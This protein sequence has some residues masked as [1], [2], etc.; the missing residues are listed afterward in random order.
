MPQIKA[1][2]IR[3][4]NVLKI[5][6]DLLVVEHMEH[7]TPGNWRAIIHTKL[8][9]LTTKNRTPKRFSSNDNVERVDLDT[10]WMQ[11]IYDQ[12]DEAVFMDINTF[13]QYHIR[14]EDIEDD[15]K[16][17]SHNDTVQVT[18]NGHD[19]IA[20]ELPTSVVLEVVEADPAVKGNTA[21]NVTK[22]ITLN[23]GLVVKA[24]PHISVGEKVKID[25]R[26][27]EFLERSRE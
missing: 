23:T 7:I 10:K 1:T 24:P 3:R 12:D 25:T 14:K 21:T 15:L 11:Y 19:P 16:Y 5:D 13:E 20:I 6:N 8:R 4:G 17:I 22:N 9:S 2:E 27:G 18:L 26:T